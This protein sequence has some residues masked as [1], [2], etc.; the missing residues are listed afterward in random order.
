MIVDIMFKTMSYQRV[1]ITKNPL[2]I[3]GYRIFYKK[4][5]FDFTFDIPYFVW[6]HMEKED[7]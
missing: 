3:F 6:I 1:Y 4:Y 5:Y 7:G 2:T